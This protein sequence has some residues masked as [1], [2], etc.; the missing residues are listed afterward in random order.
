MTLQTSVKTERRL[1]INI[2]LAFPIRGIQSRYDIIFNLT[3]NYVSSHEI[4]PNS[5]HL[6]SI[7]EICKVL[8]HV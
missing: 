5:P 8:A 7:S 3:P 4:D 6:N 1:I 2:Q